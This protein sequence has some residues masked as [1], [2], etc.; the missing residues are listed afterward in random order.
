MTMPG[1]YDSGDSGGRTEWPFRSLL[2]SVPDRDRSLLLELG[3]ARRYDRG[4]NLIRINEPGG[5]VFLITEGCVKILGDSVEGNPALLAIRVAGDI[6]GEMAVLDGQP[7]SATVQAASLTRARVIS[8]ATLHTFLEANPATQA[9]LHISV[10]TK[11]RE[12]IQHRSDLNGAPVVMRLARVIYKLGSSYGEETSEGVLIRA[13]LSQADLAALVGTTEQ[14]IR[15]AMAELRDEGLVL[16]RYRRTIITDV[17]RLGQKISGQI[18][19]G[20]GPARKKR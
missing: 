12:A 10:S 11:F 17:H 6:V 15:R 19:D 14:S 3:V 4:T 13:P 20:P 18:P 7:R 8:A 2:A 1:A 5:E 16:P 9:A